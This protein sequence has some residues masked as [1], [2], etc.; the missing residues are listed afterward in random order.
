LSLSKDW[1][2]FAFG[3]NYAEHAKELSFSKQEEPL[4]FVK[5]PHSVIEHLRLKRRPDGVTFMHVNEQRAGRWLT[6][7]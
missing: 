6:Q 5:G 1:T 3:L 4:L 7:S 2:I